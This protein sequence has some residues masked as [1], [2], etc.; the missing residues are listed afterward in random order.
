MSSLCRV[1]SSLPFAACLENPFA[2]VFG[3]PGQ[4]RERG[5]RPIPEDSGSSRRDRRPGGG[6]SENGPPAFRPRSTEDVAMVVQEWMLY[7]HER[8][9]QFFGTQEALEDVLSHIASSTTR[10]CDPVRGS[11]ERCMLWYGEV[12]DGEPQA[13]MNVFKPSE[14]AESLSFVNRVLVFVFATGEVYAEYSRMPK[15]PFTMR[16]GNQLCVNLAHIAP[17]VVLG[18]DARMEVVTVHPLPGLAG[19]MI[20][21]CTSS[22]GTE[23]GRFDVDPHSET[24]ADVRAGLAERVAVATT[25]NLRLLLPNGRLLAKVQDG[26]HLGELLK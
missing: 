7:A 4:D 17:S 24:L 1:C 25:D 16:C 2:Y 22:S 19:R 3:P 11:R 21:S 6:V 10:D 12:A 20:L 8:A 13:V 26:V 9:L 15:V 5:R 14:N 18:S 23:V